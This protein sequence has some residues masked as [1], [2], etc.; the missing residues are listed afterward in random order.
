MA[1]HSATTAGLPAGQDYE[2]EVVSVLTD[3]A[4]DD[5]DKVADLEQGQESTIVR[6]LFE[7]LSK[8]TPRVCQAAQGYWIGLDWQLG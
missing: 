3:I 4:E 1:R 6:V 2:R 5:L 7:S 8:L